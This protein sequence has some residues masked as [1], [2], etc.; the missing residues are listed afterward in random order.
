MPSRNSTTLRQKTR[1]SALALA[2]LRDGFA[3]RENDRDADDKKE[4]RENQVFDMEAL[5]PYVLN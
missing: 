3:Q 4:Q 1:L 5:P 2:A